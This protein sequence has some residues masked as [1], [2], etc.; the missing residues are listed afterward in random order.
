MLRACILLCYKLLAFAVP[1]RKAL[2]S[3][4]CVHCETSTRQKSLSHPSTIL[5]KKYIAD[6]A[7]I[8]VTLPRMCRSEREKNCT[9]GALLE[10]GR[11]ISSGIFHSFVY[12]HLYVC[13]KNIWWSYT[14][15]LRPCFLS[16]FVCVPKIQRLF[17]VEYF[18]CFG[19]YSRFPPI[20]LSTPL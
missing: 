15:N 4:S 5:S 19:T 6:N 17:C 8:A 16:P 9:L 2:I 12:Q 10:R 7:S 14:L 3:G 20:S 13:S 1:S 11:S 18:A